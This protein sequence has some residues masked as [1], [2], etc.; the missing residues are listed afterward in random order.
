VYG[1]PRGSRHLAHG[2]AEGK[3]LLLAAF[4]TQV[5]SLMH[6]MCKAEASRRTLLYPA[7]DNK[8][9]TCSVI[10]SRR[11]S[12]PDCRLAHLDLPRAGLRM[13][14]TILLSNS[15]QR[16]SPMPSQAASSASHLA[17]F[18]PH[19]C[20]PRLT[21]LPTGRPQHRQQPPHF[22]LPSQ[23]LDPRLHGP[24]TAQAAVR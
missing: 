13:T 22:V 9:Q 6:S 17:H 20:R 7:T 8:L 15:K 1:W 10:S 2:V 21:M 4:H 3:Y 14:R 11:P 12:P 24:H 19:A 23:Q 18:R 16:A 5:I